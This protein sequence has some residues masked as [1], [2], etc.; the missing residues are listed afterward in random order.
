M[1]RIDFSGVPTKGLSHSKEVEAAF[2]AFTRE[3]FVILDNIVP[4]E[5]VRA[6][7]EEFLERGG[8]HAERGPVHAS[9]PSTSTT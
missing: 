2:D 8:Q 1:I 3:G 5:T 4:R 6:L 9:L 7:H